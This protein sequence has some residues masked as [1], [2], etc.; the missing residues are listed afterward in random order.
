MPV[1]DP[2]R[3]EPRGLPQLTIAAGLVAILLLVGLAGLLY[4]R[5]HKALSDRA[6]LQVRD[7]TTLAAQLV[8]EQTLRFSELVEAHSAHLGPIVGE[9]PASLG[10]EGRRRIASELRELRM[11]TR[12]VRSAALSTID[13]HVVQVDPP[14][15][16]I[17]GQDFSYRDWF[18]GV[19]QE[20]SPYV[21][22]VFRAVS[23]G[24]PKTVTVAALVRDATGKPVAVVTASLARRTQELATAFNRT[25]G[26]GLVVTD[27][28][29]DVIA[30]SGVSSDRIMSMRGDPL[31]ARAL[32]G[33]SG[34]EA[35]DQEIAGYAPVPSTGWTVSARLPTSIALRDVRDLRT[36]TIALTAAI[37]ALLAGLTA[38]VV[39][40]Q[41]RAELLRLASAKREQAVH[42][43][44][45]VV[46]T[47]TVAQIARQ[48]GDHETADRAVHDALEESKRITAELL[49]DDVSPG[50]LVRPDPPA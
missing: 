40:F 46:Q 1:G 15:P 28:A 41:R 4:S 8:A 25:Q 32:A 7:A 49:P 17:V 24:H 44:D 39:W 26:L 6:E 29:G 31:V 23:A 36:L 30:L 43:H 33:R 9:S 13:G 35:D 37:A 2:G 11:G 21:S 20:H 22:R 42:L 10:P 12:G 5:S 18:K 16:G 14:Q 50:D 45:G 48:A 38:G 27:Q 19:T 34:T 3:P 47:L